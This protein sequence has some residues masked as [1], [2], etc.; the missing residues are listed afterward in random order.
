MRLED[1]HTG[2][3]RKRE[4]HLVSYLAEFPRFSTKRLCYARRHLINT[5]NNN[6][7]KTQEF[8]IDRNRQ[9]DSKPSILLFIYYFRFEGGIFFL[10]LLLFGNPNP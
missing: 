6:K 10:L 8:Q 4:A 3:E 9:T 1:I 5:S 2:R 7:K